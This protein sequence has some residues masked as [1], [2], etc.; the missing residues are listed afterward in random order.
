MFI[1]IL[2]FS[3]I[4]I[5]LDLVFLKKIS[6][7]NIQIFGISMVVKTLSMIFVNFI[8]ALR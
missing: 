2:A 4:S 5:H 1:L 6:S 3:R 7:E 8:A